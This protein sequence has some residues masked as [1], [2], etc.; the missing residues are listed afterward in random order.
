MSSSDNASDVEKPAASETLVESV[1][2]DIEL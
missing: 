1:F 2:I